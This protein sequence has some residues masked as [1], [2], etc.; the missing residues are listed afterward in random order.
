MNKDV[1][2]A[3]QREQY[4]AIVVGSGITGGWAAKEFTEK[5]LN[6]L[7]LE[8]G[9]NVTHGEDYI[10][11]HKPAWEMDFHRWGNLREQQEHYPLQSMVG[12]FNAYNK[13]FFVRDTE[14]PYTFSDDE[15]FLWVRGYHLGGRSL[16]WE[17]QCYRWSDL[18]FTANAR[19]GIAVDWPIRYE[20][21]APWYDYV[22]KFV[23]ISG[24]KEGLPHLPDGP[25]LPPHGDERGRASSEG[26]T[27]RR[28]R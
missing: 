13:H 12:P 24:Q 21:V 17:R 15:P 6:T 25:F 4:D 27:R 14:H 22:E 8:R 10:T 26:G 28:I 11:E 18:D 7:V 23:G 20:D 9:R 16:T 3:P 2:V 5:G 19:E 1:H